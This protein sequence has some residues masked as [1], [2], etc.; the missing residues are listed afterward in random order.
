M[1]VHPIPIR[2]IV[3]PFPVKNVSIYVVKCASSVGLVAFPIP[4]VT[5]AVWPNLL[6]ETVS[7]A[8]LPLPSVN[9]AIRKYTL[10]PLLDL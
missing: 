6:S 1:G 4:H 10:R 5:G 9:R 7:L 3:S 8:A 2:F